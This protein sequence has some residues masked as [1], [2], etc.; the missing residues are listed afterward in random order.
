LGD[1]IHDEDT[2]RRGT[3]TNVQGDTWVL[4][5]ESGPYRWTS[6]PPDRLRLIRT[7]E[8]RLREGDD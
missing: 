5:P 6:R 3:V 7:R 4:R 8:E 2:D 1:L